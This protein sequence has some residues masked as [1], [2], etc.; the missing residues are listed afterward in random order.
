VGIGFG[1]AERRADVAE[2][3]H[4]LGT[5]GFLANVAFIHGFLA[6]MFEAERGGLSDYI[7]SGGGGGLARVDYSSHMQA[8]FWG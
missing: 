5:D 3:C 6:A 8:R 7:R 4:T 2:N 1:L